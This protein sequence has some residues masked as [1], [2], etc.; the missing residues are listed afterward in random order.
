MVIP[1]W[2]SS[3]ALS[4]CSKATLLLAGSSGTRLA[5][6]PVIAAVKVVLPWSTWPMVPTFRCG[7]FLSNLPLDIA[8]RP[9]CL[10]VHR[11]ALAPLGYLLRDALRHLG[12]VIEL[13]SERRTALSLAPDGRRVTEHLG[14]RHHRADDLP[15]TAG[16]HALDLATPRREVAHDIAHE[17]LGHDDLDVHDRL[18][19]D[20]V[21]SLKSLLGRHATGDL[22]RHLGR[23]NVVERPIDELELYVHDREPGH[24]AVIQR[25]LDA[26]VH[27]RDVLTWDD[28]TDDLI[29]ELVAAL[30]VVLGIDNRV[31]IL[32]T[33][34]CLP[35]ETSLDVL[36]PLA[37]GLT[38]RHLRL[39]D[40]RVHPELAQQ[41]VEDNLQVQLAHPGD[42]RLPRL[43]VAAHAEGRILL[44]EA[45]ERDGQL[46]LIG[47]GLRL[48]SL[49]YDR[50][51][52]YH[53]L[54]HDRLAFCSDQ[55]VAG[56][57]LRETD[58]R[59]QLARV[60]LLALL[61]AVRVQLQEPAYA[62]APPLRGVHHVRAAPER[63]RI[64]PHIRQLPD[65]RVGL[66]LEGERGQ[67]A[68]LV[69]L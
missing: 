62:L 67:R 33:T 55:R 6:T 61:P 54:E 16:V 35:H 8:S 22:E 40:V 1:R 24:D 64:H 66:H 27:A 49:V 59:H 29:V 63:A 9:F 34:A 53:L 13:H 36:D 12:V 23:V 17:L 31:P 19:K 4:I 10:V 3:G 30:F 28:A 15:A 58:R 21:G 47:L 25:A 26:L 39:A 2:R 37:D 57:S 7:L 50:L 56:P 68:V 51:R 52:K 48:D 45:L 60:D 5:K 41:P 18:Q 42:D 43:L 32:A 46:L 38:V 20:R 11:G 14:E 44:C 69:G 65:V